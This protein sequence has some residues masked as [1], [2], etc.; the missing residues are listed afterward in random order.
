MGW[1][2]RGY[3]N[4]PWACGAVLAACWL[5]PGVAHAE[6]APR[7]PYDLSVT[8]DIRLVGVGGEESW[9]DGGFGKL[10]FGSGRGDDVRLRPQAVEGTIAWQPHLTWSL[11]ATIVA[12][13]QRSQD[14]PIDLSEAYLT[15]KPMPIGKVK[16]SARAGLFYPPISLEHGGPEWGVRDTI[17]PSAINSWIGE[18]VK[19][20][21]IEVTVATEFSGNR[22]SLTAGL[23]GMN[24]TAGTLLAF[25]GW[26]LHDEKATA[27]SRQPLPPL[28]GFLGMVQAPFTRPVVSLDSRLGFYAKVTWAPPGPFELQAFHYDNRANPEAFNREFQ[29]GWRTRFDHLGAILDIDDRTRLTSQAITGRTRMGFKMNGAT[30]VD[31]RFRSAF[32]LL[33]RQVGSGSVSARIE[34]FGTHS[35]GSVVASEYGENGWAISAAARRPITPFATMLIEL[36]HVESRREQ[37]EDVGLSPKQDQTLGQLALKLKI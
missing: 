25:R 30:W 12:I 8:G 15:F 2:P 22:L 31:T 10:R 9:L 27:F 29:W 32:L 14:K 1:M 5:L 13:A 11:S 19:T 35:H 17:T 3:P 4:R 16:F 37:R 24:D 6:D 28:D 18:E 21:G 23:F 7:L 34:A 26:A 36:L 20:T 33:N